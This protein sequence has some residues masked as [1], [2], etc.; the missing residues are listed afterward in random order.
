M[1]PAAPYSPLSSLFFSLKA[2]NLI[3]SHLTPARCGCA[4]CGKH[5]AKLAAAVR[6]V[7][8]CEQAHYLYAARVIGLP[9]YVGG[10]SS[11]PCG[12]RNVILASAK[13]GAFF[14]P[15]FILSL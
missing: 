15:T 4:L 8:T 1:N 13:A 14:T 12:A 7:L 6:T 2:N 10:S 5:D 9:S 11:R 3:L